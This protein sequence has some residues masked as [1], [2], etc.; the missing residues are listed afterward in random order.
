MKQ[1]RKF[2]LWI[3]LTIL[4]NSAF[5]KNIIIYSN[6]DQN[7]KISNKVEIL[8]DTEG[9]MPIEEIISSRDFKKSL[10][11]IPNLQIS[12]STFWIKFE[13]KNNTKQD[14][15]V[16]ELQY[17]IIDEVTLYRLLPTGN[18]SIE[19]SGEYVPYYNR[20][21][22][23]QDY[24]FDLN[25]PENETR[26]FIMKIKGSEQ[27]QLPLTIGPSKGILESLFTKDLIFGLYAGIIIVMFLYNLF[28]YF[29]VKDKTYLF[30]V[31]YILSVGLTQACLQGYS[32]RFFWPD[33]SFLANQSMIFSPSLAGI[34]A[35]LFVNSFLQVKIHT[36]TL[37]KISYGI[38][39]LYTIAILL[40]LFEIYHVSQQI[41]QMC[42]MIG[43]ILVFIIAYKIIKKGFREA[44]FF[45]IAWSIFLA[46][47]IIFVLRNFDF[48][49]YNN[50]TY[51][52]LQ[53]GSGLE[54]VLLSLALGD[55][56]NILK[57][58]KEE[59]QAQALDALLQN[60]LIIRNQNIVLENRVEE[61]TKKLKDIN[62]ELSTTLSELKQTQSH[63]VNA[64]KMAS[65][66]QLTA[67]IAHEINNPINFVVSNV[68]PLQRDI[69]EIYELMK[70]I[71][72]KKF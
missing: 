68:K 53:F 17:P 6:P 54:V 61:R 41:V 25:I 18:Y 65:L 44:K 62:Q 29:V 13:I 67:G 72:M 28:V 3:L 50:F 49:P 55:R 12:S 34:G 16:L 46:S 27:I 19:K 35:L 69:E 26:T 37:F 58:E 66:G 42:S 7:I 4:S 14:D 24:I 51:Y 8:E 38:I 2:F 11:A 70:V 39:V 9:K 45:L 57:K 47:V 20:K 23:Y 63:L 31:G 33:S 59:S 21:Y 71:Q 64:E 30:Y 5:S 56:I 1:S 36:P 10:E 40:G 32:S 22:K 52:A 43:S 60:E 15:I 48:L